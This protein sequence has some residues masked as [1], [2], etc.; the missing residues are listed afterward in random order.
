M[1]CFQSSLSLLIV[2]LVTGCDP[3]GMLHG[4]V[5]DGAKAPVSGATVLFSCDGK[6]V[7]VVESDARGEF[8]FKRVG[9]LSSNCGVEVRKDGYASAREPLGKACNDRKEGECRRA[10]VTVGIEPLRREGK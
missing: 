8:D 3:V 9:F 10:A 1:R 6:N 4:T 2:L 7:E 5:V